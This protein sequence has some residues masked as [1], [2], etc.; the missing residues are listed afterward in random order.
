[1]A[2]LDQPKV[3]QIKQ[4]LKWHPRGM[5]ISDLSSRLKINRNLTAKYLD[6]LLISGQVE[7]RTIG[8]A[9]LYFLSH[10]VPISAMLEFS[11][12]MVIVLDNMKKILQVNEQFLRVFNVSREKLLGKHI[13]EVD[14]PFIQ[15][16]PVK[17]SP[18]DLRANPGNVTNL[19]SLM[20]GGPHHFRL[21][22]I[23]T[24]FEDGSQ[25]ITLVIEDITQ[26][27]QFQELLSTSEAMYRSIIEDQTEFITRFLPDRTMIFTNRAYSNYVGKDPE[28]LS[29]S[30]FLP[31]LLDEDRAVVERAILSLH[32]DQP[33]TTFECRIVDSLGNTCWNQ[34]T[35]RALFN[36]SHIHVIQATGRDITR[37]KEHV[38]IERQYIRNMEFLTR[39]AMDF[40]DMGDH[41]DIYHYIASRVYGLVPHSLV[42]INSY[43]PTTQTL[44]MRCVKADSGELEYISKEMKTNIVGL[45]FP[46][47]LHHDVQYAL[48]MK[49][50][51]R[52]PD[53]YNLFFKIVPEDICK[54]VAEHLNFGVCYVMGFSRRGKVFGNIGIQLKKGMEL[55]N[56][57]IIEA[58]ISQSS[59]ALLRRHI[60]ETV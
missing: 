19:I 42:G 59:V 9:K 6:L 36:E 33:V 29:G 12:D 24:L 40:V 52:G 57:K 25:G 23:P 49:N 14:N 38:E 1:M 16:L 35:A 58:F 7:F 4:L 34:W 48:S 18:E 26:Q 5:M 41:E 11:S 32:K 50:L 37:E 54:R 45:V 30:P 8:P 31:T 13:H 44:T 21:K 46:L 56:K 27:V 2:V 53:L 3:D 17:Y 55:Q 22:Q 28:T 47:D 20:P 51:V 10:R 15:S 43:D 60:R 39:T